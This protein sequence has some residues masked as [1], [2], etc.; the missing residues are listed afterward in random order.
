[1]SE[2]QLFLTEE[3]RQFL[4]ELL[5]HSHK[6]K[7]VEERRTAFNTYRDIVVEEEHVIE[8][9]LGKLGHPAST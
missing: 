3:E 5:E 4:V 2:F 1:M 7:L 9:L 8:S 6:D